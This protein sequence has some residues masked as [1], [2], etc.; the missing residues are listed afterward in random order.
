[1]ASIALS[2]PI[3]NLD[4]FAVVVS[5][6]VASQSRFSAVIIV[7]DA[8]LPSSGF[9]EATW[10]SVSARKP[11]SVP[12]KV[13]IYTPLEVSLSDLNGSA[14]TRAASL[15]IGKRVAGDLFCSMGT[16]EPCLTDSISKGHEKLEPSS[17][18]A[19]I[20]KSIRSFFMSCSIRQ[21]R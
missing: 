13:S 10:C 9:P 14:R 1:M 4:D 6:L 18:V 3:P 7:P 21:C 11:T 16:L 5:I 20:V 15:R 19:N 2:W 8:L 12:P 17:N